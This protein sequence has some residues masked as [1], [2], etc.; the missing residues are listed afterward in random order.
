MA[1]KN[2]KKTNFSL[3]RL[4]YNDKYLII[5]SLC[6]AVLV[7]TV[8]SLNIGIDETKTIKV[9]VPISLGD[10]VSEQLG[11]QYYSL[12]DTLEL[13][14]TISGAKY[15]IGQVT[16]DDLN[17]KFDTS[18]VNRIGE[19]SIPILVTNGSKTLDFN[20]TST[21]PSSIDGYFDVNDTKTFDLYLKYDDSA[22]AEGYSFG[23]A[24]LSED[25]VII[26]GPKTYVDKIDRASVNVD[27]GA[28]KDLTEPYS[29]ECK[30][31]IEGSGVE[32]SYL[33]MTSKSDLKTPIK[34]VSVT[35]PVLKERMLPVDVAFE[36]V[37]KSIAD[38]IVDVRYSLDSIDAGVLDSAD[39][40]TAQIG[41]ISYNQLTVGRNEFNFDI[42]NLKGITL[43]SDKHKSVDIVVTV[44]DK[45]EEMRIPVSESD[46]I[47]TG[48]KDNNKAK[49]KDISMNYVTVVA[50]K[51]TNVSAADIELKC[52]VSEVSKDNKYPVDVLIKRHNNSW[53]YGTYE[54]TVN[55]TK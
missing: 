33:T 20:V 11:M 8:T 23:N 25:K 51:N 48:V 54:A 27:F 55:I 4:I 52:D 45:Y 43:L 39:I 26:S 31:N 1:E 3:K 7:W 50:P 38:D 6:L 37:P 19:Q 41:T 12:H 9:D 24:V 2:T 30:I 32:T 17:I 53:I 40:T 49:V 16:G 34:T 28:D 46:V 29:A 22:V 42:T 14:V 5:F 21:Y 47:I 44:S 36:D 13:S 35:L 15:V 18:S 10:E